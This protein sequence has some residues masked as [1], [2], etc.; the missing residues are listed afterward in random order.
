[1]LLFCVAIALV[2]VNADA[3]KLVIK[4]REWGQTTPMLAVSPDGA[5]LLF[6]NDPGLDGREIAN[7][8]LRIA[9]ARNPGLLASFGEH[10]FQKWWSEGLVGV[11][12][13]ATLAIGTQSQFDYLNALLR[14]EVVKE[15]GPYLN[16]LRGVLSEEQIREAAWA[17][18]TGEPA[19]YGE[20]LSPIAADWYRPRAGTSSCES[21]VCEP[22]TDPDGSVLCPGQCI[23]DC[24]PPCATCETIIVP[25]PKL[26]L[27]VR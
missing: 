24:D 26:G 4:D 20:K 7:G 23:T 17:P 15:L 13:D 16:Y 9:E 1:M 22:C 6:I 14:A 2:A 27:K 10:L 21:A 11:R 19:D 5:G 18:P 25:A 3:A 12:A 8:L